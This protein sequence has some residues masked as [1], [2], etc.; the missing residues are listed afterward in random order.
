MSTAMLASCGGGDP[1]TGLWEGTLDGNRPVT[2]IVLG[3]GSY[4]L[5]YGGTPGSF[6]GGVVR[7]T[8]EFRGATFTSTDGVDFHFAFPPQPLTAAMI[9]SSR[10]DKQY[11]NYR[12]RFADVSDFTYVIVGAVN[13]DSLKPI[14]EKSHGSLPGSGRKETC[15]HVGMNSA[16]G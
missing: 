15:K 12:D 6:G 16:T 8:G 14:V 3:D 4:Y 13:V 9:K 7:G 11:E 5:K 10:Y 2:A 1:Y